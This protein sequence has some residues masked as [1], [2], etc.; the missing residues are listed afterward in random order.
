MSWRGAR[1]VVPAFFALLVALGIAG[2]AMILWLM[3]YKPGAA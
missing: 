2:L 1:R 3:V